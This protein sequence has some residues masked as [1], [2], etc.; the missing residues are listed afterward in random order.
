MVQ[1]GVVRGEDLEQMTPD[2]LDDILLHTEELV[3]ARMKPEQ[4]LQIVESCQRL[5]AVVTVTGDGIN[6]AAAIR[7]A[8]VGIAMGSG[9]AYST[10]CA[11]IVLLDDN[12]SS[13]VCGVEEGRLMFENL[14]KCLLYSLSSN[15]SELAAFLF[16]MIAGI[17]LPLGVLAVLCIDL[18]TDMLPAVSLAFEESEENLMKRKPRNPDTDHLINEKLIFLSFGQI[19]LIQAAAGFFTYFVIMAENGFW[20]ERLIDIRNE[21]NSFAINDLKDSYFQEWTYEDRKQ[22][23]FTCQSGFLFSV[24]VV[25]WFSA[26][27][28]RSRR[29]SMVQR[30][31]N[32]HV[33]NFAIIFETVL[34]LLIIYIPGNSEGLQLAPLWSVVWLLP[35]MAFSIVLVSYEEL[36]KAISR[37]RP[38]AWVDRETHY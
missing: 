37:K 18:G 30:P 35:G 31:F 3:F 5:G 23:E 6:D 38:G 15:V 24:V 28:A 26:I 2:I 7:R 10:K 22:L 12:F 8:D 11:D 25:Q 19:G 20:P 34:A 14:K 21:W 16:S 4:K 13:I 17:P 36:R 1:S 32:N 27:Q 29:K 33:L 9:A